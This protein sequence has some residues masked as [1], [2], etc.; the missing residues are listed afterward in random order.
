MLDIQAAP[1]VTNIPPAEALP[2]PRRQPTPA[3]TAAPAVLVVDDHP[4]VRDTLRRGLERQGFYVWLAASGWEAVDIYQHRWDEF[5]AVLLD[6]RMPGLDGPQTLRC[7][8]HINPSVQACFMTGD[9]GTYTEAQL[10]KEG[11]ARVIAKPFHLDDIVTVVRQLADNT[12]ALPRPA[13]S[14]P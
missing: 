11:A 14:R 6:V 7:L 13:L 9:S 5:A 12:L 4:Y 8:S 10:L 2:E 1:T 3:Y